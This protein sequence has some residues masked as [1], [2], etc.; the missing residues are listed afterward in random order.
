M[1]VIGQCF[2]SSSPLH[3]CGTDESLGLRMAGIQTLLLFGCS[4]VLKRPQPPACL[5]VKPQRTNMSSS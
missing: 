5:P 3:A 2:L 1:A 4:A